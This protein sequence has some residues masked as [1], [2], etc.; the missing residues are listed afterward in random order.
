MKQDILP[1]QGK[2]EYLDALEIAVERE[3]KAKYM[4]DMMADYVDSKRM[5][6]KLKFL[7][8]EEQNHRDNVEGLY[9]KI[10]GTTKNFDEQTRLPSEKS[11]KEAQK[12]SLDELINLAIQKELEAQQFYKELAQN[13]KEEAISTLFHYLAGEEHNHQEILELELKLLKGAKPLGVETSVQMVPA[14]YKEWW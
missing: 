11:V 6:N 1:S 12:L 3:I 2:T 7:A 4:Y 5:K 8:S 14:V 13:S 10:S 9:K